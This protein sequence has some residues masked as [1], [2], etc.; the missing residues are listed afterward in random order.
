MIALH[1]TLLIVIVVAV[2][3]LYIVQ[4]KRITAKNGEITVLTKQLEAAEAATESAKNE[5]AT[6]VDDAVKREKDACERIMA[7]REKAH[8]QVLAEKERT[9]KDALA[10]KERTYVS[11]MEEQ[12]KR[13]DVALANA[14]NQL[15]VAT[16]EMLRERQKEFSESSRQGIG[17]LVAPLKETI[18]KM[19]RAMADNTEK[20]SELRGQMKESVDS[21]L[22][23]SA[24]AQRS[25]DELSNALK[26]RTKVQGDW[27]ETVLKELLDSNGLQ[28]GVHY[29]TQFVMRD[30]KGNIVRDEA[31]HSF[32]PDV[33]VHLD[34]KR[35]M[36]ID[37]KVSLTAY[38]DYVNAEDE[39][40]KQ[41]ALKAH[42]ASLQQHV[43]ELA[44]KDYSKYLAAD[45]QT[46]DYV[47]MFVPNHAALLTAMNEQPDLWRRAM[48]RNVYIA[49]EQ[50]LFAAMKLV[51]M[52]WT[53]HAQEE[54]CREVFVLAEEMVSRVKAFEKSFDNIGTAL[55][56]A[57]AAYE[58]GGK[59]LADRG[60]SI[61][62]TRDKIIA[63][64]DKVGVAPEQTNIEDKS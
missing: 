12:Q 57:Q 41:N 16:S 32:R 40:T 55:K 13:F 35:D 30:K 58:E 2:C 60:Q 29:D 17:S 1:V 33:I 43:K 21:M 11:A 14:Q 7:D 20:Q 6:R 15:K 9:Y 48:E 61:I 26:H 53:Q 56:K 36:I 44:N 19:E 45:R 22:R 54:N 23:Q 4:S 63:L 62:K 24:A 5:T 38:V 18:D 27:G 64:S 3:A 49:D 34:G 46:P 50:T 42:I 39:L 37:S 51:S 10:E 47:V 52:A 25:A 8:E 59:K 31:G 28:E